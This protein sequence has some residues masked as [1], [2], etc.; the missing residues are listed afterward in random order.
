MSRLSIECFVPELGAYVEENDIRPGQKPGYIKQLIRGDMQPRTSCVYLLR[1][2][3]KSAVIEKIYPKEE[4]HIGTNLYCI[5]P[6]NYEP[7]LVATLKRGQEV[8]EIP[9]ETPYEGPRRY[10]F[11]YRA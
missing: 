6:V 11:T 9:I 3:P 8:A 4:L 10:R 7:E 1:C 5:V 2:F